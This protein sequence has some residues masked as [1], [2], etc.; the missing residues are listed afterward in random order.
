MEFEV[1]R[2]IILDG[3]ESIEASSYFALYYQILQVGG[4]PR[5]KG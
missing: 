4:T 2:K 5:E 1:K 3:S